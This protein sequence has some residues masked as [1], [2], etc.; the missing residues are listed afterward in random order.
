MYSVIRAA[1]VVSLSCAA[2]AC[3]H[4]DEIT[5]QKY[6]GLVVGHAAPLKI[7]IAKALRANPGKPVPQAGALQLPPPAGVDPLKFDF[8][9]VTAGGVI[10]IQDRKHAILLVQE[11]VVT[12]G[13]VKWTCT[14]QPAEAKPKLCGSDYE[15]SM[16]LTS[17]R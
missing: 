10:I 16:S 12:A 1:V 2:I 3:D 4:V 9:W 13:G 14:V 5:P 6:V 15:G 17:S 7:E 8:G 11:P